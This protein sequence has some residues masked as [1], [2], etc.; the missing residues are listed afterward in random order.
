MLP[1]LVAEWPYGTAP[2]SNFF[3]LVAYLWVLRGKPGDGQNDVTSL[4][5]SLR[6]LS[7]DPSNP[8]AYSLIPV[9]AWY[10]NNLISNPC[11][12]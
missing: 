3:V 1:L 6:A 5:R 9:H 2:L 11:V 10:N 7:K 4:T 8:D 12:S